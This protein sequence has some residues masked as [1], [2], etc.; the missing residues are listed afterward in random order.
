MKYQVRLTLKAEQDIT[1]ILDWFHEQ[2]APAAGVKWLANLKLSIE[3]RIT[4]QYSAARKPNSQ[5]IA[6]DS[7]RIWEATQFR[8]LIRQGAIRTSGECWKHGVHFGRAGNTTRREAITGSS[9]LISRKN[10][11]L[12]RA[13]G[14]QAFK[15]S[16]TPKN[17]NREEEPV[18]TEE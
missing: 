16:Q 2:T 8:A 17:R 1:S 7:S 3:N 11:S 12:G 6:D 4:S 10:V 18:N 14:E 9:S 5:A 13:V 15:C